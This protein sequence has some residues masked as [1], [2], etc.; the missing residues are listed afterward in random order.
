MEYARAVS[1]L[2]VVSPRLRLPCMPAA[3]KGVLRQGPWVQASL[4]QAPVSPTGR[5]LEMR[6][7]DRCT[8]RLSHGRRTHW[9]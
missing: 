4:D 1:P 6:P 5:P 8:V 7:S 2:G 9:L 3:Y